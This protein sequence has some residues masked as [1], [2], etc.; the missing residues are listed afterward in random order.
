MSAKGVLE[1][2][3]SRPLCSSL[4]GVAGGESNDSVDSVWH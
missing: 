1:V 4:I 3:W 2:G